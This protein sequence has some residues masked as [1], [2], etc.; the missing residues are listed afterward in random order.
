M[1]QFVNCGGK[2][3]KFEIPG[4]PVPKQR[5]RFGKHGNVYT[6]KETRDYEALVEVIAKQHFQAPFA[7]KV[8]VRIEVSGNGGDLDN[9]A[10]SILDGLTG[11]AFKDDKQVCYLQVWRVSGSSKVIV[12]VEEVER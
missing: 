3:V 1:T 8:A 12:Q 11:V 6:P 7:G 4:R 2:K 9:V 10:K 5:P